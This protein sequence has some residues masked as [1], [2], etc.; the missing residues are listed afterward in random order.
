MQSVEARGNIGGAGADQ[1]LQLQ[2]IL[3]QCPRLF[4]AFSIVVGLM[5]LAVWWLG[6]PQVSAIFSG[7]PTMTP[8]TAVMAV[9]AGTSLS[10]LAPLTTTTARVVAGQLCASVVASI[11]GLMLA[12]HILDRDFGIDRLLFQAINPSIDVRLFPERPGLQTVGAFG[13]IAAALLTL[14]R[15]TA[16]GLRPAEMLALLSGTISLIALLGHLFRIA[17]FYGPPT[18]LPYTGM[19]V[20]TS[21]VLFASS[22]G[23]LAARIDEGVLS[24][25]VSR[26]SGGIAARQL[27]T[28]LVAFVPIVCV[29]AVATRLGA[30]GAPTGAALIVLVAI[31]GGTALFLRV[32]RSMNRL[33]AERS[34]AEAQL[35]TSQERLELALRGAEIATWDWDVRSGKV[36]VN[37]RWSEMRGF[38]ADSLE[39]DVSAWTAIV[40]PD[41]RP[42]VQSTLTDHLQGRVHEYQTEHRVRTVSGGWIWVLVRGRVSARDEEGQPIR[43]VGTALD[44]TSRKRYED[45]QAFLAEAGAILASSLEY[46]EHAD[47]HR[48]VRGAGVRRPVRCRSRGGRRRPTAQDIHTGSVEGVG[49]RRARWSPDRS[50]ATAP[51]L[52]HPRDEAAHPHGNGATGADR[53]VEADR[54]APPGAGRHANQLH[55]RGSSAGTWP[56]GGHH[57][58]RTVEVVPVVRTV[59]SAPG[60]GARRARVARA[61]ER[62]PLPRRAARH[63]GAR[64]R[65][66]SRRARSPQSA[67]DHPHAAAILRRTGDP[68]RSAGLRKPV[69]SIE[70]A[71]HRMNRLIQ[72]LL[73]VTRMEAG[74]LSIEAGA[75]APRARLVSEV[76]EAQR[77]LAASASLELEL[78]L[79]A[80][81]PEV[82]ADR[83]RLLQVFENLIGNAVKFTEPGGRI[84]VGAA[85]RDAE[86]L[87]W[88][89]DTGPGI[90]A[91]D[92]PHVFDRFWQAGSGAAP[93]CRARTTHRQGHRRSARRSHLGG[94]HARPWKHVLLHRSRSASVARLGVARRRGA[95]CS[96]HRRSRVTRLPLGSRSRWHNHLHHLFEEPP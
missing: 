86:V 51:D 24:I 70:R 10:L 50:H 81:L 4:G 84:T 3:K 20:P 33:D 22:A 60:R 54:G 82:W 25:L 95:A 27:M 89:T 46:E 76:V 2:R 9:L 5:D 57:L 18:A 7:L 38:G 72:D 41:D 92:L 40:H 8:N 23:I 1:V 37:E 91:D 12:E 67:R 58:V 28:S 19:S 77:A 68:N 47:E 79:D 74:R 62:A 15:R 71:A 83:D 94:E 34:Q 87:F 32:S 65:A 11:A 69:E 56:S 6:R 16:R 44:I 45:E 78:E 75:R 59:G 93:R 43:M 36:I 53:I 64:Q 85:P 30:L 61:R 63:R 29:L 90:E 96:E 66:R 17:A 48:P 80:D 35:L 55:H 73:D 42:R 49:W 39:Q 14:D 26:D 21:F 31:V 88:V 13:A 52:D